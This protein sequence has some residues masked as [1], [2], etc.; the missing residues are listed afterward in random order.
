V[1]GHAFR[2]IGQRTQL[3]NMVRGHAAEFGLIV[4]KGMSNI[5]PLLS[6]IEQSTTIPAEV[7]AIALVGRQIDA[8]DV[9]IVETDAK[10]AA[11]HRTNALSRAM[12]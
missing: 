3:A 5:A 1:A 9:Q 11:A 4:G 8:L 10:I 6:K 12:R 7:K 2:L